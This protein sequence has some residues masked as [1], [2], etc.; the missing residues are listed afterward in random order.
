[1]AT[2]HWAKWVGVGLIALLAM[3]GGMSVT[4][5]VVETRRDLAYLRVARL[6]F[7]QAQAQ[8]AKTP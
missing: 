4:S 8:K 6:Q 5:W 3:A 7:L 1:M 2:M